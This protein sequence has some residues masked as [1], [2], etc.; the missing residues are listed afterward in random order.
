M[1]TQPITIERAAPHTRAPTAIDTAA[2]RMDA[3]LDTYAR[4]VPDHVDQME[5][6]YQAWRAQSGA[7]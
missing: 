2:A 7:A 4:H 6:V 3:W 5:T 1:Q